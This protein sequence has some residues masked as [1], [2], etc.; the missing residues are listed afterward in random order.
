MKRAVLSLL[1]LVLL[2][3]AIA[4]SPRPQ[5]VQAITLEQADAACSAFSRD[6]YTSCR[7]TSNQTSDQ[8]LAKS[9]DIY[10]GCM[11]AH[12]FTPQSPPIN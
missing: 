1:L 10:Y 4:L 3:I 6:Y 5:V 9:W 7:L 2:A 12:G 8:C 11:A